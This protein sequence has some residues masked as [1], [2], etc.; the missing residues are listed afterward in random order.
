[1]ISHIFE[2]F[3]TTK[4]ETSGVGLGLSVV[5][6]VVHGHGGEITVQSDPGV[7]TVFAITLPRRRKPEG[8]SHEG[9]AAVGADSSGG[10]RKEGDR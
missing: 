7:G 6:G 3:V 1:M 10:E 8:E 9:L 2:P 4:G 5:Y